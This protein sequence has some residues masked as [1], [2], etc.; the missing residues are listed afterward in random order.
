MWGPG[1]AFSKSESIFLG[2]EWVNETA[3]IGGIA[4]SQHVQLTP[5]IPS[6]QITPAIPSVQLTPFIPS[7]QAT[8]AIPAVF[9]P[10]IPSVCVFGVCTPAVPRKQ[11][12]PAI[13]AVFSP[14]IPAT[15]SPFIPALFSPEIP[16]AFG[17]TRT[18]AQLGIHS[19]GK[20]GLEF[21]YNI[22]SGT[23]DS[24]L[25]FAALADL[26]TSVNRSEFVDLGTSTGFISGSFLTQSP[27][28]EAYMSGIL[29]LSG[30]IDATACGTLL[31][32]ATGTS[33]L[34]GASLDQRI[35]SI[36]PNGL[37]LLDGLLPG[38]KP[39]AQ[40]S[41]FNQS[42]TLEGGATVTPPAVGFKL[43]GPLGLS[44]VNTLP[45]GP[46]LTVDLAEVTVQVPDIATTGVKTG[47][48]VNAS[49]R[50]DLLTATIDIDGAASLLGGLPPAGINFAPIDAGPFKIEVSLDVIDVDIGPALGV[51]QTFELTPKLMVDLAFDR[52]VEIAGSL[53]L[54]TAWSGAWDE[55]PDIAL[56]E[57]TEVTPTFWLD[58]LLSN[59]TG[60]DLGLF[61]TFDFFKF[62]ATGTVA[63]LEILD[64][65]PLSLSAL[66]GLGDT[67]F[68][69]DKIGFNVFEN[70]FAVGGFGK[71]EGASF[72][73]TAVPVPAAAWLLG[74][75]LG[76]LGLMRR[77]TA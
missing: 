54:Q 55:L 53:G 75:A 29:K 9:T 76:A 38:D 58:V 14:A 33:Q 22:S 18:G 41:I 6:V 60:L 71:I 50:D 66:L 15:F 26:P 57:T 68:E 35:L 52:A 13:P 40:V 37:K 5:F 1:A 16:A 21:G 23:V 73:I 11:I 28:L 56:F 43:T 46:T 19:S 42:L 2:K 32:C 17:D 20:V 36:D 8:P 49:G 30:S 39:V 70:A 65:G 27:Q 64:I 24:S 44:I 74:S 12:T 77:R 31:G 72:S 45:P 67:L 4:G 25:A 62:S 7:V 48:T 69:T 3:N 61:G 63:G 51:T 10:G 47:D 59:E 34:P